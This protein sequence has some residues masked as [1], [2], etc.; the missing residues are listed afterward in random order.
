VVSN[1][2]S[3][4]NVVISWPA[5]ATGYQL[6]NHSDLSTV[7]G[8]SPVTNT[9]AVIGN[10]KVVELEANGARTWFRLRKQR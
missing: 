3:G 8:W 9:P 6:Y 10:D 2:R 4:T 7:S 5:T 1:T